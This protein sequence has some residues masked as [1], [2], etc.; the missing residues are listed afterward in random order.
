MFSSF[1]TFSQQETEAGRY[2]LRKIM[3]LKTQFYQNWKGYYSITKRLDNYG[4]QS[5][6]NY[7][8]SFE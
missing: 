7:S 6:E 8:K 2:K 3:V 5:R 1:L 4:D